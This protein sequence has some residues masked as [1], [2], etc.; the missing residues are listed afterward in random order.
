M[1]LFGRPV[2]RILM[3]ADSSMA[4]LRKSSTKV[5]MRD[6]HCATTIGLNMVSFAYGLVYLAAVLDLIGP[7][8]EMMFFVICGFAVKLVFLI[9]FVGI[10]SSHFFDLLVTLIANKLLPFSRSKRSKADLEA[11]V[12]DADPLVD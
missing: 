4:M 10:R 1:P 6:L 12:V 11:G 9:A 3:R 8:R 5:Q 7:R 2:V